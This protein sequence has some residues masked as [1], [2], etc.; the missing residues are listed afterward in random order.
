MSFLRHEE[1]TY[2]PVLKDICEA[3]YTV[4]IHRSRA[5]DAGYMLRS[6]ITGQPFLVERD[7]LVP[8]QN[9]VNQLMSTA[10]FDFIHADQLTMVQ[11]SLCSLHA[12]PGAKP[13]VI[14]D[15]HNAVWTIL[16]R[17]QG[18]ASWFL[19]PILGAEVG[20]VKRYEGELLATVDHVL[21]VT[22][23]DRD[24]FEL[25]FRDLKVTAS[26]RV[27]RI[28]VVPI[29]VDTQQLQPIQR[30]PD[31][32]HILTLGTLHYPPNADGI[33]W[34]FNE[35]FP[36]ISQ[37]APGA[38]LTIIGKNP[39]CRLSQSCS[40]PPGYNQCNRLCARPGSFFRKEF[41]CGCTGAGRGWDAS[42]NS[43]GICLRHARDHDNRGVR[44][45]R[46]RPRT[47]VLVADD[48]ADFADSSHSSS[49]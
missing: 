4:P 33:R 38:T 15:A 8:M 7:H 40:P 35:V 34:F 45:H 24:A 36:L 43:R 16:E 39:S 6:Y 18:N 27:A 9:L 47:D 48:A 1:E 5:A 44:G 25:A 32:K 22:D 31:S 13:K 30:K 49:E 23:V 21:A 2:I 17:M 19:K 46:S 10:E 14:F 12:A 28:S 20:R 26:E 3:V 37:R 29:A 42:P 11:F 41:R